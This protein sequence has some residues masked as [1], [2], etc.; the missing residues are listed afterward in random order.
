MMSCRR[1]HSVVG[2]EENSVCTNQ[3]E[4]M[5]MRKND[6]SAQSPSMAHIMM[7]TTPRTAE[8]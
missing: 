7:V 8:P 5:N 2:E 6:Y 1:P 3:T 4:A